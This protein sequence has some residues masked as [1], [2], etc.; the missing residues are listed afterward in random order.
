MPSKINLDDNLWASMHR[1]TH[2]CSTFSAVSV[3]RA[4]PLSPPRTMCFRTSF[5]PLV[6]SN[7]ATFMGYIGCAISMLGSHKRKRSHSSAHT[8]LSFAVFHVP[9]LCLHD[10]FGYSCP[11]W[12]RLR[13]RSVR[14]VCA[15]QNNLIVLVLQ[16]LLIDIHTQTHTQWAFNMLI[17]VLGFVTFCACNGSR[18]H[19]LTSLMAD[20]TCKCACERTVF[21]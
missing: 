17:L 5:Q 1:A 15:S 14:P 4:R 20:G 12:A 18:L 11:M 7:R 9:P 10:S 13:L 2:S 6:S 21:C 16:N 8:L 3:L 19:W